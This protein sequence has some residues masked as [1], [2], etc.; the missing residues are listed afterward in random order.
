MS[1]QG[2][3]DRSREAT[4]LL[5]RGKR[6]SGTNQL[7]E[8]SGARKSRRVESQQ[9]RLRAEQELPG[10]GRKKGKG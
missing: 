7:L 1:E 4:W 3:L 9:A 8:A 5:R 10:E 6:T 2:K